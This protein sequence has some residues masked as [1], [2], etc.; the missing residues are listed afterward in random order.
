MDIFELMILVMNVYT[1][2]W[3]KLILMLK[4]VNIIL[5]IYKD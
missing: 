1:V 2:D 3:K 4:M 5:L